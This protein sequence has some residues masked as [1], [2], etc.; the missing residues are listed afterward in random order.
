MVCSACSINVVA[1]DLSLEFNT[2]KSHAVVFGKMHKYELPPL[3]LCSTIADWCSSIKYLGINLH[4]D[5]CLKFD[6]MPTKRAFY[7]VCN[8]IFMR[9]NAAGELVLLTLQASYSLS[10]LMYAIPALSLN[11]RQVDQLNVC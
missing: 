7:S 1:D 11:S 8:S 4:G 6:I 3:Y 5:R 2:S 9:G 10:V